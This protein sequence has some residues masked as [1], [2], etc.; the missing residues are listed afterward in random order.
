MDAVV[1]DAVTDAVQQLTLN[2]FD[3]STPEGT[4]PDWSADV[5]TRYRAEESG[6][7][8]VTLEFSGRARLYA[9]DKPL[10]TG[11]REASPMVIGPYYVLHAVL[12]LTA[13]QEVEL[14]GGLRHQRGHRRARAAGRPHLRLGV[15]GPGDELA[16]AV[17]LAADS[18]VAVVLGGRLSGEAMDVESLESADDRPR[19]SPR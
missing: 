12:D 15:A 14:R 8:T 2:R 17:A 1:R 6:S 4:G 7:H 19:C 3:L 9:D 16:K 18:D 5:R 11:F 13:G 10:V